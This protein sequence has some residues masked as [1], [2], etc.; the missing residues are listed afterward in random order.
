MN[1]PELEQI[2]YSIKYKTKQENITPINLKYFT[3]YDKL[4]ALGYDNELLQSI[5]ICNTRS[6]FVDKLIK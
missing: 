4:Q 5:A 6:Y 2:L 1:K 3:E